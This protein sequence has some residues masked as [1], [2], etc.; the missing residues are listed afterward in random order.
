MPD[1]SRHAGTQLEALQILRSE[2][3]LPE[4]EREMVVGYIRYLSRKSKNRNTTALLR[5]IM[6]DLEKKRHHN[7]AYRV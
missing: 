2:D 3:D 6:E 5:G 1:K 4:E 7:P